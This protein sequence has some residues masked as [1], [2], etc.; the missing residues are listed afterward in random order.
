MQ[1]T[2]L[3]AAR[4]EERQS[5]MQ[6]EMRQFQDQVVTERRKHEESI[7]SQSQRWNDDHHLPMYCYVLLKAHTNYTGA[8]IYK[9]HARSLP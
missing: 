8:P 7:A 6:G 4:A 3:Q 1:S 9:V 5:A 2:E